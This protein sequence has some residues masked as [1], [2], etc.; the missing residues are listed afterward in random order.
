MLTL[1]LISLQRG[2]PLFPAVRLESPAAGGFTFT[3]QPLES[4]GDWSRQTLA[5]FVRTV[6][7]CALRCIMLRHWRTLLFCSGSIFKHSAGLCPLIILGRL[8]GR[9]AIGPS[10]YLFV[11]VCVCV[12][13]RVSKS[14]GW[15]KS[16]LS[17]RNAACFCWFRGCYYVFV[18]LFFFSLFFCFSIV[19]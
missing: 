13:A 10:S 5:D 16:W 19:Y 3:G 1:P 12:C 17:C 2:G 14:H 18:F 9:W 8:G 7:E 6:N 11:R 4:F 15:A